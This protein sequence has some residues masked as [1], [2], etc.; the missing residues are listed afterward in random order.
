[1]LARMHLAAESYGAP[2]RS[3]RPLVAGFTIFNSQVPGEALE[4]YLR[5]RPALANDAHTRRDSEKALDLLTPYHARLVTL[6]SGL[7]SLWTHND[8]HA[9]NLF[10]SSAASDARATSAI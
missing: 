8:L 3:I 1:M 7:P 4:S 6:L 10:W 5:S 2:S 9:S